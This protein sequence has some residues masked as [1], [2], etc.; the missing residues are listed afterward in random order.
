MKR[1]VQTVGAKCYSLF[2]CDLD[3][4]VQI[5]LEVPSMPRRPCPSEMMQCPDDPGSAQ[6]ETGIAIFRTLVLRMRRPEVSGI[7]SRNCVFDNF[8]DG[9]LH[10]V[11][12]PLR[13]RDRNMPSNIDEVYGHG[14]HNPCFDVEQLL[15]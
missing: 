1:A 12:V 11:R 4:S 7:A 9:N 2:A 6:V 10:L 15:A 8:V 13:R 14:A 5:A 3:Q